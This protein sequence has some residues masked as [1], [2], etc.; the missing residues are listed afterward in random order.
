MSEN[1]IRYIQINHQSITA[2]I[3]I[4]V[5]QASKCKDFT[6]HGDKV[7]LTSSPKP[8]ITNPI[9]LC[10]HRAVIK[11]PSRQHCVDWTGP[12]KS[13]LFL[14]ENRLRVNTNGVA[15][16]GMA[17]KR[18]KQPADSD[19]SR[20]R[21]SSSIPDTYSAKVRTGPAESAAKYCTSP[22]LCLGPRTYISVVRVY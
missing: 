19:S 3:I 13:D 11:S 2:K 16:R 15:C 20:G 5:Q 4:Q 8:W 6:F 10:L 12:D 7:T 1:I 14:A 21:P 22:P 9:R 18:R 17:R